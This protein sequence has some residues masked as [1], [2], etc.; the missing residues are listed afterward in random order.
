MIQSNQIE[1]RGLC[2]RVFNIALVFLDLN[3]RV[4]K[5]YI[6]AI[7]ACF[8]CFSDLSAQTDLISWSS[9]KLYGKTD[10][11]FQYA[12]KPI[13]R[14]RNDLQEYNNSSLDFMISKRTRSNWSF[15]YL[16]RVWYIKDGP[17]R[18][19]WWF[20]V[21]KSNTLGSKW[22]IK[23]RM[24]WHI[25]FD[26]KLEDANFLR[27][28]PTVHYKYSNDLSF[29]LGSELWWQLDGV[30]DLR[31]F[32]HQAGFNYGLSERMSLDLQYWYERS[33]GLDPYF[34]FH[35]LVVNLNY[36]I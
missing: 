35:T 31:R 2:L 19:F 36:R 1:R 7:S 21:A 13:I 5:K 29:Y 24:R 16:Y 4:L 8:F 3:S 6:L 23:N 22:S 9:I 28:L 12:F 32:R 20:D 26:S 10:S 34:L 15:R 33:R 14:H 18:T 27:Y 11:G 30:N 25:A 17:N